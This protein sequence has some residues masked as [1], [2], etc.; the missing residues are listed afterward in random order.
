MQSQE[1]RSAYDRLV[2]KTCLYSNLIFFVCH[3]GYLIFFLITE[4]YLL[5]WIDLGSIFVYAF[6]FILVKFKQYGIYAIITGAEI[7]AF[8]TFAT[9]AC[10]FQAGFHLCLIGLCILAFYSGYFSINKSRII[11]P[12]YWCLLMFVLYIF[13]YFYCLYNEPVYNLSILLNSILFVS[14]LL[15]VFLF[16]TIFLYTFVRYV[17]RLERRIISE[18]RTDKLTQVANRYGLLD[19]MDK[20]GDKSNYYLSIFDIDD[21]KVVN[22]E[23]GHI[24]GDHM[25]VE[26]AEI[27]KNNSTEDF[28][29]RFGG[30][31]FIV[32]TKIDDEA[33]K[34]IEDIRKKIEEHVFKFNGIDL[35]ATITIG[36]AKYDEGMSIDEWIIQADKRLYDGKTSGKNK[37]VFN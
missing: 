3:L 31:E 25:L 9:A 37:V 5:A 34:K 20:L 23:Y 13:L 2:D 28:V 10:G 14:H 27:A 1:D 32:I 19:Y 26:I 6:L 22:D 24:C 18:S 7:T 21:F 15:I 30:E 33:I 36:V 16:T 4:I 8:M 29:S 11:K 35:H 17:V 12:Q